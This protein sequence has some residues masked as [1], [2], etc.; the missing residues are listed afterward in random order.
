MRQGERGRQRERGRRQTADAY[1]RLE[2]T[3]HAQQEQK[4]L[5][6]EKKGA[7]RTAYQAVCRLEIA[8]DQ[9]LS[10]PAVQ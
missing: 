8:V 1:E 9:R 2:S 6:K 7:S 5:G 4:T 10:V 3:V